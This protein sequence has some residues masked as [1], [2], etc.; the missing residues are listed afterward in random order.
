MKILTVIWKIPRNLAI[1]LVWFYQK[2][3]S[4]D[5]SKI[6]KVIFPNGYCRYTPTCS[7]YAKLAI[8][9]YGFIHGTIKSIWRVFR[10]NP[11]SR[12]GCDLP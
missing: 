8:K 5:H 4:P 2:T 6:M 1:G 7:E 11:W 9:K 10:C 3:L 12:G